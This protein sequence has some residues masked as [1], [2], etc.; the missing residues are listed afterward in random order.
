[1]AKACIETTM[2]HKHETRMPGDELIWLFVVGDMVVFTLFFC[3][4]GYFRADDL[5]LY[6]ASQAKLG[7][8]YGAINSLVLLLSSWLMV[9][10][11]GA[12]REG[13]HRLASH[14]I[15]GAFL[16]GLAF[17]VAKVLEYQGKLGAGIGLTHNEF[18]TFYYLLTGL[19]F[20]HLLC[21][22][23]VLAWFW[24][25]LRR[26]APNAEDLNNL[27]STAIY[28]HMVDLLWILIFTLLY[29]LP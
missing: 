14:F 15:G 22:L 5:V 3:T 9:L 28:W 8:H 17:S 11:L 16:C 19:H 18:F 29:L 20:A 27:E 26:R 7:V 2:A 13:R 21:G 25:P 23:G 6:Q 24:F 4:F 1:V 12:A 10:S